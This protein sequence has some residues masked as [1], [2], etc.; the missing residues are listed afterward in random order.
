MELLNEASNFAAVQQLLRTNPY[1]ASY[2][3]S[4]QLMPPGTAP[5]RFWPPPSGAPTFGASP[6]TAASMLPLA[7]FPFPPAAAPF[8]IANNAMAA[9]STDR[10]KS[11]RSPDIVS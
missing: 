6:A 9:V 1:W 2:L 7:V 8:G 4:S 3:A 11:E 5:P 10:E